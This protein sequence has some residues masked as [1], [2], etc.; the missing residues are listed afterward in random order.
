MDRDQKSS[1][2]ED[3]KGLL[4]GAKAMV[5]LSQKGVKV[6]QSTPF[7]RSLRK[8]GASIRVIKNT[9][10]ARAIESTPYAFF[11][12]MLKGPLALAYTEKDPVAL[13]KALTAYLKGNQKVAV[14][15]GALGNRPITEADLKALAALPSPEVLKGMFLGAL[16]GVPKKFLGLLQAPARDFLGVLK[17]RERQLEG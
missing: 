3:L 4:A 14:V 9:L 12:A 10:F 13:A 2:V 17:A 8:E 11:G 16:V 15:G 6:D 1:V 7:R 5:L